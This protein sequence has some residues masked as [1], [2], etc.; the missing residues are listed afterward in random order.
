MTIGSTRALQMLWTFK[1]IAAKEKDFFSKSARSCEVRTD[2]T[3]LLNIIRDS[4][5]II[6]SI[7]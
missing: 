3:P 2:V 5:T 7:R 6:Y 4:A 1:D